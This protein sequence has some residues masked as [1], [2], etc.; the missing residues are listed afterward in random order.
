MKID[1]AIDTN[2]KLD[3]IQNFK[4]RSNDEMLTVRK[5]AGGF[6]AYKIESN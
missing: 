2:I 5:K 3:E 6:E 4:L 1:S